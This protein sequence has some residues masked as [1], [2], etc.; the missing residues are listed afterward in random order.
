MAILNYTDVPL[1]AGNSLPRS[2]DEERDTI[3]E[4]DRSANQNLKDGDVFCLID[5]SWL[6]GWQEYVGYICANS[7]LNGNHA[8]A[9]LKP[10]KIDN[11]KLVSYEAEQSTGVTLRRNLQEGEDYM[12]VPL[13]VWKKLHEWYH[14]GPELPRKIISEGVNAKR[15]T[16]EVYLLSL[17]LVD[18]RDQSQK[19]IT[20]SRSASVG[21]LY[22]MV[23]KLLNLDVKKVEIWDNFDKQKP[24]ALNF[25]DETLQEA[26]L[27]MDQEILLKIKDNLL[28]PSNSNEDSTGNQL[29]LLP[30]EPFRSPI[31]I[32]GGPTSTNGSAGPGTFL[33]EGTSYSSSLRDPEEDVDFLSNVTKIDGRGLTGLNNLG[34]TCFMN[35][36][37]QCLVHT[38]NLVQF[39]LEDYTQEINEL[40]PLGMKGELAI[41]FGDLLRE[42][43]SS[44]RSSVAPRTF[45]STLARFAPQFI[46][47]NQHDSQELLAFLLDGLHEDLN[48]VRKKPYVEAKD[49]NGR[50]DEE[51]ADECWEIHKARNDSIIVDIC[52]GQ[53]KSTVVCPV[54][55]K[56]SVTFDPFMYLSLPL[57]S[58]TTRSMTVCVFSGDGSSLP[59]PF[60]VD[61]PKTGT[62]RDLLQALC[63]TCN[64]PSSEDLL[65]AE[66]FDNRIYR[67][68]DFYE[69]LSGIRDDDRLAAYKLPKNYKEFVRLE[70]LH[71][72]ANSPLE[73]RSSILQENHF[74]TPLITILP[75]EA[76]TG[77]D[78]YTIVTNLLSSI[79]R[80]KTYLSPS[81]TSKSSGN[82]STSP[83]STILTYDT[84]PSSSDSELSTSFMEIV[85]EDDD[86]LRSLK[87]ILTDEKGNNQ[88][89]LDGDTVINTGTCVRVSLEWSD[90]STELYSFDYLDDIPEVFKPTSFSAKKPKQEAITLFSCLDSFLKEEPLGP[91]DMWFCPNCKEHRQAT[92]KLDLWRLPE[93][94]VVHLKRFSYS[95]FLKNKL[96]TFVDF[97]VHNLDLS[98]YV[99][100][101][102]AAAPQSYV[103]ELYAVSNHYGGLGGGHYTAYAKLIEGNSWYHFDDSHVS[104]VSEDSIK[105]QAAY[106][107]FYRRVK[108][109]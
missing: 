105:T 97:P 69:S 83:D 2:S 93:V 40:N 55:T 39:F 109:E 89:P 47:Y 19:T 73:H 52:Q 66:V 4:L 5:A 87:L 22:S 6:R 64:L 37:L 56:V 99:N 68:L 49:P 1:L 23:C 78:I 12:L 9:P 60:T 76:K 101:N 18:A 88:V 90:K 103:Y 20:I 92:K 82:L 98:K 16:V 34:N 36:A 45:K 28:F 41:A 17:K 65:L 10:G 30:M 107:L 54:C 8:H 46:G 53:Y 50:P 91:D 77:A 44:E 24:V 48:R 33:L 11:S 61:V 15:L 75:K 102:G 32:A 72:R 84:D 42:L 80:C 7:Y 25:F 27:Q 67:Y 74:G 95:R 35:S 51:Y 85:V 3:K 59:T 108:V 70:I 71:H 31:T 86:T 100:R 63:T 81:G 29:A 21:E 96:D 104:S 43:W 94:L 38:P 58:K 57:P 14:G 62:C 26:Q 13:E 79:S 106:V